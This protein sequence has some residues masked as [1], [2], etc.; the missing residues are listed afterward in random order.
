MKECRKLKKRR[1]RTRAMM[2]RWKGS[3]EKEGVRTE[4]AESRNKKV[5]HE[6]EED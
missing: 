4:D 1:K 6:D 5:R 3:R 2:R